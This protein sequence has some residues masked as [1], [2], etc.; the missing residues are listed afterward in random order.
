[1]G[2]FRELVLLLFM[3]LEVENFGSKLDLI[4]IATNKDIYV[5]L[6]WK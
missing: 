6:F 4:A 3:I 1:M 2:R 5:S